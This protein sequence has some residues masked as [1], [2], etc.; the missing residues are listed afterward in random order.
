MKK[1]GSLWVPSKSELIHQAKQLRSM[2]RKNEGVN[3]H[4]YFDPKS[5]KF[6]FGRSDESEETVSNSYIKIPYRMGTYEEQT[7][8]SVDYVRTQILTYVVDLSGG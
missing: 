4:C 2:C 7:E 6:I 1:Y 8:E 5:G 3:F